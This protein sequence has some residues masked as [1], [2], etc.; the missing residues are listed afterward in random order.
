MRADTAVPADSVQT[1]FSGDGEKK[2]IQT[3]YT[4]RVNCQA[5]RQPQRNRR[6]E[7]FHPLCRTGKT[8]CYSGYVRQT[9]TINNPENTS[10]PPDIR[11]PSRSISPDK[12]SRAGRK[13]P[14][15]L[16]PE[17]IMQ[18]RPLAEKTVRK[19]VCDRQNIGTAGQSAQPQHHPADSLNGKA[20]GYRPVENGPFQTRPDSTAAKR[21][22]PF[23]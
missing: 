8:G 23:T 10:F 14:Y 4:A 7:R 12:I 6:P 9:T 17:T 18:T 22:N 20:S 21:G 2:P 5:Y 16:L 11:A 13:Q 19:T 3:L 15:P 1:V